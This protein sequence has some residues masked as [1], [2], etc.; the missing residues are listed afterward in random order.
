MPLRTNCK[1]GWGGV[2]G[3]ANIISP[4]HANARYAM[5]KPALKQTVVY[6]YPVLPPG[7]QSHPHRASD[8][9]AVRSCH[10]LAY[11]ASSIIHPDAHGLLTG[12]MDVA[13]IPS[14]FNG[15][16]ATIFVGCSTPV[17]PTYDIGLQHTIQ[18]VQRHS[19]TNS[20]APM[21]TTC[22]I[23]SAFLDCLFRRLW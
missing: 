13:W 4:S 12:R 1:R 23:Q 20:T 11:T 19:V 17:L 18:S 7:L 2:G 15:V 3:S 5:I 6:I 9:P 21:P 14:D 10:S 8:T 22:G 16:H